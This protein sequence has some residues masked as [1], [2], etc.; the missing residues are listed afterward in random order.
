MTAS[1]VAWLL[2]HFESFLLVLLRV[3]VLLLFLPL[4]DSQM[5]PVQIK[6]YSVLVISLMLTPVVLGALPP[7]PSS[8]WEGG[9]VLITEFLLGLTLSLTVRFLFAGIRMAGQL[10]GVQM[11]FGM[12]TLID[13]QSEGQGSL[14]SGFMYLAALVLFLVV[15]GHHLLLRALVKS[16]LLVPVGFHSPNFAS[17]P[18]TIIGLGGQM[19]IMAVKLL[20]PIMVVL[21]LIQVALGLVAKTVP[22]VQVLFVSFPLTIGLGLLF[23]AALL[24]LLTPYLVGHFQGLELV[25]DRVLRTLHG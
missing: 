15:N 23:L 16:F 25:L 11:G 10:V 24:P 17:L 18:Q 21:F 9:R 22:Q 3:S 6:V 19:F 7:F 8:I 20:A 14:L 5:I 12:V 2:V 4:W 13:P 1:S